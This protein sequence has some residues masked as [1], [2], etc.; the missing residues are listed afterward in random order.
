MHAGEYAVLALPAP[1]EHVD[2]QIAVGS[3]STALV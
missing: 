3:E 1:T 2:H